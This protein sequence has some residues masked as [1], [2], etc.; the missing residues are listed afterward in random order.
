MSH[1][2][3]S[4]RPRASDSPWR[5]PSGCLLQRRQA[6]RGEFQGADL[7]GG[8]FQEADLSGAIGLTIDQLATVKTLYKATLDPA[9]LQ[10]VE[11]RHPQ[12]RKLP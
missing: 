5:G 11:K 3:R 9:L 2:A 6:H 1:L 8:N 7:R 10:E 12:L 4:E